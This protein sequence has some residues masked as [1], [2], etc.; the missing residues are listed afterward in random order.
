MF[1]DEWE[2]LSDDL[3]GEVLRSLHRWRAPGLGA[4]SFQLLVSS[5]FSFLFILFFILFFF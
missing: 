1:G 4:L 5:F 3:W 2:T